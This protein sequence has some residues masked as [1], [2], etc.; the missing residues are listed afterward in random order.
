M[1]RR[2]L[3]RTTLNHFLTAQKFSK[4]TLKVS[5]I[6]ILR[7]LAQEL[8]LDS[9]RGGETLNAISIYLSLL[10]YAYELS[11]ISKNTCLI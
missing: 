6:L 2:V 9:T 8:H 4:M 5:L 3:P 10:R 1:L 7:G 11:E